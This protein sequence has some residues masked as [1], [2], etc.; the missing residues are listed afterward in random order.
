MPL[1][2]AYSIHSIFNI[3]TCQFVNTMYILL[4]M[5]FKDNEGNFY[6]GA[7]NKTNK[8]VSQHEKI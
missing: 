4:Q 8:T 5:A 1:D 6:F 3:P 7:S 2:E